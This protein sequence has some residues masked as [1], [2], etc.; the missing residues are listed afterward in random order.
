MGPLRI[1]LNP[2]KLLTFQIHIQICFIFVTSSCALL[3]YTLMSLKNQYFLQD[4]YFLQL[5]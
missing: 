4:D 5:S 3:H 1:D 2:W